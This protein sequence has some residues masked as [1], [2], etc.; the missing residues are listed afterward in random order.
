MM[1]PK[2]NIVYIGQEQH[3]VTQAVE[4]RLSEAGFNVIALP[5]DIDEINR[6]RHGRNGRKA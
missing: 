3:I 2:R 1:K 6:N 5:S 4:N